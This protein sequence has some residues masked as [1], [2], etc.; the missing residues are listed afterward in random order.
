[1]KQS[2][3]RQKESK[4][5]IPYFL[6]FLCASILC[7]FFATLCFY[8]S[9][10]NFMIKCRLVFAVVGCVLF[11]AAYCLSINFLKQNN[12]KALRSLTALYLFL[13]FVLV[14]VYVGQKTGIFQLLKT[15]DKLQELIRRAGWWMPACY[16]LLQ[17]FQVTVLPIP[18]IVSTLVGVTLFGAF[19]ATIY[20][21]IGIFLGSLTAFFLGRKFGKKTV[22]WIVGKESLES[23]QK[24]FKGKDTI[25]LSAMFLLPMFPDDILC[26]IAGLSSISARYFIIMIAITRL[27]GIIASAYSFEIIPFNTGWGIALWGCIFI[28]LLLLC[29]IFYKN[30]DAINAKIKKTLGKHRKRKNK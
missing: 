22:V 11:I 21:F 2:V 26:F 12:I 24:K 28:I 10:Q 8:T 19:K 29:I 20:S 25:L 14:F 15:P 13:I 27:L 7:V 5:F 1:M 18:S 16:I 23:W 9:K 3:E 17:Y 6:F 4:G 30:M